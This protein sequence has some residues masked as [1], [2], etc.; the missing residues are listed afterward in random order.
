MITLGLD[1]SLRAYGSSIVNTDAIGLERRIASAHYGTLSSSVPVAR[2][3]HFQSIVKDLIEKYKPD[4]VGI[5]S[6][7]YGGG[8]FQTVHFGLMMFSLVPIFEARVDC[9]LFDPATLKLLAK[10]DPKL[11]KGLMGK[12]DMQRRVQLLT[13]DPHIID[14]NEADAF[15]VAYYTARLIGLIKGEI[16]PEELTP[17]EKQVFVLRTKKVKTIKGTKIRRIGHVFRANSRYFEYSK[18]PVGDIALPKKS[19]ISKEII[20]FLEN[21]E[22]QL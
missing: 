11:K 20:E 7:A 3:I 14:N 8:P 6:P 1:P 17:S 13:N 22:E 12:L 19:E 15:L 4:A 5:E 21:L 2:F 16:K 9:V 18:V 10:E